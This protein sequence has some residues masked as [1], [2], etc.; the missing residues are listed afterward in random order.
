MQHES[1]WGTRMTFGAHQST[2]ARGPPYK[3]LNNQL[4]TWNLRVAEMG[5]TIARWSNFPSEWKVYS[6]WFTLWLSPKI[7][8]AADRIQQ[9][10]AYPVASFP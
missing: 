5:I 10:P 7:R 1:H 4:G 8:P 3:L 2:F 6:P 9:D